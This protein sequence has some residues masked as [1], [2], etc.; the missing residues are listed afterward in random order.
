MD[1]VYTALQITHTCSQPMP[2]VFKWNINFTLL[3]LLLHLIHHV[4]K[5]CETN[6]TIHS[7]CLCK[8]LQV[9]L[10]PDHSSGI[11]IWNILTQNWF[12]YISLLWLT[13]PLYTFYYTCIFLDQPVISC[14]FDKSLPSQRP[15]STCLFDYFFTMCSS[16]IVIVYS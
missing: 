10:I 4:D 1:Q 7:A 16:Y 8:R 2:S 15:S 6:I 14:T 5:S 13:F 3:K 11:L 12:L 9:H